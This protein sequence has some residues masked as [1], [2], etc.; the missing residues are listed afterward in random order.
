[1]S[2]FLPETAGAPDWAFSADQDLRCPECDALLAG[3]NWKLEGEGDE[4][5]ATAMIL[6]PCSHV[7]D[8][9]VWELK[10]SGRDRRLGTVIR[11]PR[12]ERKED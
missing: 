3:L 11:T 2:E 9:A 6:V 10:F 5:K 1:M 8:M 4:A 7:L 12:F